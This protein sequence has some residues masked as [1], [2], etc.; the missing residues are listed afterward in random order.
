[1]V[2]PPVTKET[3]GT[4]KPVFWYF[5]VEKRVSIIGCYCYS[6]EWLEMQQ[7]GTLWVRVRLGA[8]LTY[9]RT[10]LGG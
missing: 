8:G 1:M 4:Q 5:L 9:T 3:D 6:K 10:L 2:L 7:A